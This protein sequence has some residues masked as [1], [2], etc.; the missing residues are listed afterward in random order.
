MSLVLV[1]AIL[2]QIPFSRHYFY[3]FFPLK[4]EKQWLN[5]LYVVTARVRYNN[6]NTRD[7]YPI[8]RDMVIPAGHT[9]CKLYCQPIL[10]LYVDLQ[11]MKLL[12]ISHE[13]HRI[14]CDYNIG[15][16]AMIFSTDHP[17]LSGGVLQ[18]GDLLTICLQHHLLKFVRLSQ[19]EAL[20]FVCFIILLISPWMNNEWWIIQLFNVQNNTPTITCILSVIWN[21]IWLLTHILCL[22]KQM[23]H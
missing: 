12:W 17:R 20:S 14:R 4:F 6:W 5:Q 19:S 22:Q 18:F 13:L 8:N 23:V 1:Y 9:S 10:W 15:W 16:I 21:S 3:S 11:T 7:N 2:A